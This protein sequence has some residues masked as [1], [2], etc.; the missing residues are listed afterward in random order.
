MALRPIEP[1]VSSS[2]RQDALLA[3]RTDVVGL[4]N[5]CR[6]DMVDIGEMIDLEG[7]GRSMRGDSMCGSTDTLE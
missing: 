4:G 6:K 7:I 1:S 3:N 5:L 2:S